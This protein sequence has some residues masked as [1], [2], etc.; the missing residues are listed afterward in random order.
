MRHGVAGNRLGR[1]Q[2]LRKATIRDMAKATLLRQRILTTKAKAK[3][4]RKLVEKLITLGKKGTLAHKRRAFA[5]LVDHNLVKEL[6][7]NIAK[8]F[9]TRQ[10]GYTRIIP[11]GFRRG[12]NAQL[13]YLE[14]TE[15]SEIIVSKPKTDAVA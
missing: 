10:G 15:N 11:L 2:S 12:D 7:D 8:R 5:I 13:I 3:E 6:F 9:N 4:A 14:L 1:N